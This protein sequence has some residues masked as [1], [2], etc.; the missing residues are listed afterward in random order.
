M[1]P[2]D[3]MAVP[4]GVFQ[5]NLY[6]WRKSETL[7]AW[8]AADEYALHHIHGEDSLKG[9]DALLIL[10]D[11]FGAL[12]VALADYGPQMMSDS[13]ISHR[14]V[15]ANLAQNGQEL[16]SVRLLNSLQYPDGPCD[17]ALVKIPKHLSL[18]EDQLYRIRRSLHPDTHIIGAGMARHIHTSTLELFERLVGPTRTSLARKKARLIFCRPNPAIDPGDS[19]Y[20]TY[21]TLENTAYRLANQAGLFSQEKLDNGTR[22]LLEHIPRSDRKQSIIDL[23]CGSGVIGMVAAERN[24]AA[25]VTFVDESFLAVASAEENFRAVF[26]DRRWAAFRATDCLN[27]IPGGSADLILTNPPFHRDRAVGD[28]VAWQMFSESGSTLK[29]G[30]T[31]MVVGNR[32]LG[33]HTKLKRLFGN[34]HTRSTDAKFVVLESVR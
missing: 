33:Y 34:C 14:G 19:P 24:P 2:P 28:A 17:I 18:L 22:L 5:L 13:F 12:S 29:P 8:D 26:S 31:L 16:T 25:A 6:P 10:N 15:A 30:G 4:Q 3:R 23:G 21:Y 27:G 32:H 9:G 20:P 11:G 1:Q 7:R